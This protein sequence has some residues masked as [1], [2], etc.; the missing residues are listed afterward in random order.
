MSAASGGA[1]PFRSE[2]SPQPAAGGGS[3]AP[4]ARS[5]RF[6]IVVDVSGSM[7]DSEVHGVPTPFDRLGDAVPAL[8]MGLRREPSLRGRTHVSVVTFAKTP[9]VLLPS[10][11]VDDFTELEPLV[12][13]GTTDYGA[14]F[15]FLDRLIEQE[16][17]QLPL[18]AGRSWYRPAVFFLTDGQPQT[19]THVIPEEEWAPARAR[20]VSRHGANIVALGFGD[21]EEAPLARVASRVGGS[22]MAFIDEGAHSSADLIDSIKTALMRSILRSAQS[23]DFDCPVPRGMRRIDRPLAP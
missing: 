20:L 6:Y 21:V 14:V 22:L 8:I 19:E 7:D 5:Y 18:P 2:G 3:A 9:S 10:V 15:A 12:L 16:D 17:E 1:R 4:S 13:G 23:G 11:R